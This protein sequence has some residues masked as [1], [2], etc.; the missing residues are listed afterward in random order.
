MPLDAKNRIHGEEAN[1][2]LAKHSSNFPIQ[3]MYSLVIG[4]VTSAAHKGLPT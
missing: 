4:R 1:E 3:P 2:K